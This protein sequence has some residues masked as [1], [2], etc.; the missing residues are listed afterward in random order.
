M[1]LRIERHEV[2]DEA[3]AEATEDFP[4]R[5]A[6][7]VHM[8]QN[9]GRDGFGWEL[10]ARDLQDY[11]AARS[12]SAPLAETDIKAAMCS[13][14][15]ARLG[16]LVLDTAP[17]SEGVGVHLSYTGTGISYHDQEDEVGG[18]GTDA[19]DRPPHD[20]RPADPDD[21]RATLYL[22]VISDQHVRFA[23]ILAGLPLEFGEDRVLEKGLVDYAFGFPAGRDPL[24]KPGE[25]T[26]GIEAHFVSLEHAPGPHR[27]R[28]EQAGNELLLLHALQS[29]DE[30]AFWSR[31]RARLERF[32]DEH[33][34][35]TA[36]RALLPTPE[37]AL[38]ALAVRLEGWQVPFDSDYLP[39]YLL[40]SAEQA[41]ARAQSVG[42]YGADK[43][44]E[45][46]QA[47]AEGPLVV[48]RPTDAFAH[49][50]RKTVEERFERYVRDIRSPEIIRDRLPSALTE[51][52]R[53]ELRK[54]RF[55]SV[56]D[57]QARHPRQLAALA[58]I[59]QAS[60]A[61][62][63]CVES[64]EDTIDVTLDGTTG[65]LRTFGRNSDTSEGDL[66]IGLERALMAGSRE[67]LEFL[68][69][70]LERFF[71]REGDAEQ[72]YATFG[73][74]NYAFQAYLRS[75]RA[76]GW[77]RDGGATVVLNEH[78]DGL[79]REALERHL[80]EWEEDERPGRPPSAAILLSQLAAGDEEGFNL[81]L[82]DLLVRHRKAFA[83]GKRNGDSDGLIDTRALALACLARAKGWD[84][85]VESDYLPDGVLERAGAM[86]R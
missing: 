48:E 84:V 10:I 60:V 20:G 26:R 7:D 65:P 58:H 56:I 13:A 29:G 74:Y 12:V 8:Q 69:D 86:F 21:W 62:F 4:D 32:R 73:L 27:P 51:D 53:S 45:A 72:G 71:L 57:P 76:R 42:L 41:R 40:E 25:M 15:E 17:T 3:L 28:L 82:A 75:E 34:S 39:P 16:G 35:E 54:F 43:R 33:G 70:H 85:R 50:A 31:M 9:S 78:V 61:K 44:P 11:A 80:E 59:S 49:A 23:R 55:A 30:E 19:C 63:M 67:H 24:L 77:V 38:A 6:G 5:I 79:V 66:F 2:S 36:L 1:S 81:A 52:A 22:N 18:D 64:S 37:I 83:F 68:L 47:L 46:M 14:A